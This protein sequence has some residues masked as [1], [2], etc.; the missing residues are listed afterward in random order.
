MAVMDPMSRG[1]GGAAV[2]EHAGIEV[3]RGVLEQEALLVLG[4][5]LHSLRTGRPHITWAY[6]VDADE[7]HGVQVLTELRRTHELAIRRDGTIEEG[8]PGGHGTEVFRAP[9]GP[10]GDVPG[11]A[12]GTLVDAGARSVL[13]EGGA[14]EAAQ[15]LADAVDRVIIDVP[16]TSPSSRPTTASAVGPELVPSGFRLVG[17]QPHGLYVRLMAE[18]AIADQQPGRGL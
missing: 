2:L 13:I 11:K 14:N 10:L 5:W 16:R 1:E 8:V 9:S 7:D 18:Q 15:L 3:A 4:P 12:L 17:V 6:T